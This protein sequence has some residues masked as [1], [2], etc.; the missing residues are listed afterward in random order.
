MMPDSP[1]Y[2]VRSP[3]EM[4]GQSGLSEVLASDVPGQSGLS[5]DRGDQYV[6]LMTSRSIRATALD[7][8][9]NNGDLA[10]RSANSSWRSSE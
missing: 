6:L 2:P 1:D 4:P 3:F 8:T 10:W 9:S 5:D 7:T